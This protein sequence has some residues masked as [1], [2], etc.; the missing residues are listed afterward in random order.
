MHPRRLSARRPRR[1]YAALLT[2]ALLL[3][4]LSACT[5]AEPADSGAPS[6][7]AA[8]APRSAS[9][10]PGAASDEAS[11]Q[12]VSTERSVIRTGELLIEVSDP[13]GAMDRV[14]AIVTDLD[15]TIESEHV[16]RSGDGANAEAS[17]TVRVPSQ[18]LDDAFSELAGV[19]SVVSQSRSAVDVTAERVDL[20]ARVEAL[21]RSVQRLTDLMSGAATTGELI[22]AESA[23]AERQQELDGLRAQ[24][25]VLE[26]Q[27]DEATVTVTLSAPS[28]L[29][30]GGPANFW[31]GLL[32]GFASMGAAASG[33][34]VLLGVLLPWL[35]LGALGA[36]AAWFAVRRTRRRRTRLTAEPASETRRRSSSGPPEPAP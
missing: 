29:P 30:G 25:E 31:E 11:G 19:G 12:D 18:R 21:E 28:A 10:E 4:P 20:Q 7:G 23:L 22:E 8:P 9:S 26:G 2:A 13:S 32:T 6:S 5:G 14:R 15:G 16:Q 33:A 17:M 36:G 1:T 27:V 34:L 35:L 3:V 24:L